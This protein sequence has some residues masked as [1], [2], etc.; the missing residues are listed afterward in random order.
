M[1]DDGSRKAFDPEKLDETRPEKTDRGFFDTPIEKIVRAEAIPGEKKPEKKKRKKLKKAVKRHAKQK[2]H[3]E[4]TTLEKKSSAQKP[5]QVW[6]R[7]LL[8][9]QNQIANTLRKKTDRVELSTIDT[10]QL[11]IAERLVALGAIASE[12]K[13]KSMERKMV[14][15]HIDF[16]GLL[17]EKIEDPSIR[18][19]K[20]IEEIHGSILSGQTVQKESPPPLE[21]NDAPM[22]SLTS[23]N[24]IVIPKLEDSAIKTKELPPLSIRASNPVTV[25]AF[26]A[27]IALPETHAKNNLTKQPSAS[28]RV[29][30]TKENKP[31]FR[32]EEQLTTT[33]K[34]TVEQIREDVHRAVTITKQMETVLKTVQ[35]VMVYRAHDNAENNDPSAPLDAMAS[36]S[37]P[38]RK[39]LVNKEPRSTPTDLV[40]QRPEVIASAVDKTAAIKDETKQQ[41]DA[42]LSNKPEAA[43]PKSAVD[44]W[45]ID[46]LLRAATVI[47][48]GSGRYLHNE[49]K[50]D[51]IDKAGLIKVVKAYRKNRD[52]RYEYDTQTERYI[53]KNKAERGEIIEPLNR[54]RDPPT[55]QPAK[56]PQS[57][58]TFVEPSTIHT[59]SSPTVRRDSTQKI[60]NRPN[61]Y[62][63]QSLN[64]SKTV[65]FVALI[66]LAAIV[67]A[68]SVQ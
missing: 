49:F 37:T 2:L 54:S 57:A 45:H 9:R 7:R 48:L 19:P 52:Y 11:L 66:V 4:Q 8:H 50:R 13:P 24:S 68:L 64:Q 22:P 28:K 41:P 60:N 16:M 14:N 55:A 1:N 33:S 30:S 65:L 42:P 58:K 36:K 17:A 21:V 3:S 47:H 38:K 39:V 46:D 31:P 67:I 29:D 56:L 12:T 44:T 23:R 27:S 32:E 61:T 40:A 6:R 18:V 51:K 10:A 35:A 15:T 63:T 25:G 59:P 5:R 26:V 62:L 34:E 53:A 43:F 20:E